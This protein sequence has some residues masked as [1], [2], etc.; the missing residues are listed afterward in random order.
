MEGAV[1]FFQGDFAALHLG[2][3]K[4][5]WPFA[6]LKVKALFEEKMSLFLSINVYYTQHLNRNC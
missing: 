6:Q 1:L 2:R 5:T 3:G 4:L